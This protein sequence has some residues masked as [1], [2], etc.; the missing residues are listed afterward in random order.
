MGAHD[1]R[2]STASLPP[3]T[4]GKGLAEAG[5]CHW[6][7]KVVLSSFGSTLTPLFHFLRHPHSHPSPHHQGPF[8]P[9]S[10]RFTHYRDSLTT[11]DKAPILTCVSMVFKSTPSAPKKG[12]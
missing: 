4:R 10:V 1:G 12:V 9:H 2:P 6:G 11:F 3:K 7:I 5:Q 8:S